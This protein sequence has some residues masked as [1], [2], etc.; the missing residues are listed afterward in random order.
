MVNPGGIW[1]YLHLCVSPATKFLPVIAFRWTGTHRDYDRI[2]VKQV[3]YE[4]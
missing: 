3:K 2:D 1:R 4:E